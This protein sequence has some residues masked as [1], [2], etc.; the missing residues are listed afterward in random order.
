MGDVVGTI[1]IG[2]FVGDAVGFGV[3]GAGLGS[4]GGCVIGALVTGMNGASVCF[5]GDVVGDISPGDEGGFAAFG[6]AV[7]VCAIA[8]DCKLLAAINCNIIV[9]ATIFCIIQNL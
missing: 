2:D 9:A 4:T 3:I 8:I 6:A 7:E 5:T 1:I